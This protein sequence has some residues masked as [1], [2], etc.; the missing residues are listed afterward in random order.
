MGKYD[1][2]AFGWDDWNGDYNDVEAWTPNRTAYWN[3]RSESD[4]YLLTA[5]RYVMALIV[6]RVVSMLDAGWLAYRYNKG[7]YDDGR[8]TLDFRPGYGNSQIG[9]SCRF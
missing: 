8:W 1:A 3:M 2:F 9:L 4:D 6:N 7:S 5:D